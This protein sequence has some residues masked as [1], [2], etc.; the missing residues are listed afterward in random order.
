[1]KTSK[2]QLNKG[3][4][5]IKGRYIQFRLD[6]DTYQL[7]NLFST[8]F[9]ISKSKLARRSIIKH[10]LTF[11]N[12]EHPNP[13]LLISQN[14][15]KFL[16]DNASPDLMRQV[17]YTSYQNGIADT[18]YLAKG[19]GEYIPPELKFTT[20]KERL[21]ALNRYIFSKDMQNW[22]EEIEWF[23]KGSTVILQG[24]HNL[25]PNFS[26][27]IKYLME[28]YT[29][30]TNYELMKETFTEII[31]KSKNK[32]QSEELK[33]KYKIVLVFKPRS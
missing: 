8:R 11:D 12:P 21:I 18:K 29:E 10:I 20:F 25:G 27:F 1:M 3:K 31:T 5:K 23:E 2:N 13:K 14:E 22:F 19:F 6:E 26:L 33:R 28:F 32:G 16:L 15:L 17:A 24:I 9:H 7:I 4:N 30:D